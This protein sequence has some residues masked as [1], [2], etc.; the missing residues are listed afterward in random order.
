MK[1]FAV[2][3]RVV[4]REYSDLDA[5]NEYEEDALRGVVKKI[6]ES[7][8]LL[9]KWDDFWH[10]KEHAEAMPEDLI[11]ETEANEILAKLEAEY[12]VWADP[13][14]EKMEEAGKLLREAGKL[15]REAGKLAAK[16]KRD[17]SEMHE[18]VAPLISADGFYWLVY[19]FFE[20]LRHQ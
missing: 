15:L 16:Q 9:I 5:Y 4:S 10:N 14:Q 13:I 17:L 19:L 18:F 2:G 7:G 11:S 12:K 20:L 6:H 3:D 1:T 8:K